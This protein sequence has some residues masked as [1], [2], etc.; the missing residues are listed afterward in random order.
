MWVVTVAGKLFIQKSAQVD[1]GFTVETK[2]LDAFC[3]SEPQYILTRSE[4]CGHLLCA[5]PA[6]LSV[7]HALKKCYCTLKQMTHKCRNF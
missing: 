4:Y 6:L 5:W 7:F 2:L 3:S 1:N